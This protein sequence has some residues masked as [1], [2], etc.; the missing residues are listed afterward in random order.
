MWGAIISGILGLGQMGYGAYQKGRAKKWAMNNPQ[1]EYTIP[2]MYYSNL[3]LAEQQAQTGFSPET[4]NFLSQS[5]QQNQAQA[6]NAILQA[7]GSVN[8]IAQIYAAT[9]DRMRAIGL[10]D[11]KLKIAKINQLYDARKDLAGQQMTQWK[12]NIFDKW[13]NAAA[14]NAV[15]MSNA[16]STMNSGL[17]TTLS[18][19]GQGVNYASNQN[20]M[21][22]SSIV[23]TPNQTD[24]ILSNNANQYE[25]ADWMQ[26]TPQ[27]I[28]QF[29]QNGQNGYNAPTS[30]NNL[31]LT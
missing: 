15:N 29:N 27:Q 16:N 10:V 18:A 17:N 11:E 26:Q 24:V 13:K 5:A 6:T 4:L 8:N 23:E 3:G 19:I 1:P 28:Q 20:R 22:S 14:A 25:S 12:L 7:G 30:F 2:S 31:F 21:P 9:N